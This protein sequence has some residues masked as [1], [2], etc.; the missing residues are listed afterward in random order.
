MKIWGRGNSADWVVGGGGRLCPRWNADREGA[1]I[2]LRLELWRTGGATEDASYG[3]RGAMA[4]ILLRIKLRRTR[5]LQRAGRGV[6]AGGV[7]VLCRT[8][9]GLRMRPARLQ[10]E[11]CQRLR[12]VMQG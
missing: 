1:A 8:D 12:I 7:G 9:T 4:G 10:M 3:G 2:L 6:E 11:A 5:R